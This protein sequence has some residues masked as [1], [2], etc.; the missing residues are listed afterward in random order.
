M[1]FIHNWIWF[2]TKKMDLYIKFFSM[3]TVVITQIF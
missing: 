2:A 1:E 3:K